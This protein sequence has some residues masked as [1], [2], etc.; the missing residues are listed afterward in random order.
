MKRWMAV[1]IA[2]TLA[3]ACGRG[4]VTDATAPGALTDEAGGVLDVPE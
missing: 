3:I 4:G 1:M 2:V